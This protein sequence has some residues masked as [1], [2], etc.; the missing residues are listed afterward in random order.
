[1]PMAIRP[2]R[3]TASAMTGFLGTPVAIPVPD[4]NFSADAAALLSNSQVSRRR[5]TFTSPLTTTLSGWT[6]K[7]RSEHRQRRILCVAGGNRTAVVDNVTSGQRSIPLDN[8]VEWIG[9]QP[10]SSY[11]AFCYYPGELYN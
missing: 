10:G 8:N 4:G 6:V 9:N 11:N 1:M 5:F 7:C 3:S 2:T